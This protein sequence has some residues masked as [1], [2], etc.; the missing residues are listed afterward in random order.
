[1]TESLRTA[2]LVKT[3]LV[4]AIRSADDQGSD[5]QFRIEVFSWSEQEY[6]CQAWRLDTYC[7]QPTLQAKPSPLADEEWLVLDHGLEWR[8]LRAATSDELLIL[9]FDEIA[10]RLGV[11]V[12]VPAIVVTDGS[13]QPQPIEPVLVLRRAQGCQVPPSVQLKHG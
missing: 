13:D 3:V 10:R 4:E 1:M 2:T 8:Q 12:H 9:V 6:S 7:V 5:I 11:N